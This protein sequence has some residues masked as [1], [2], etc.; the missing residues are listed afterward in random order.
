M[1]PLT[2]PNS[3]FPLRRFP[4]HT[5][6]PRTQPPPSDPLLSSVTRPLPPSPQPGCQRVRR[7]GGRARTCPR[8]P[9]PDNAR[10]N[11]AR[12]RRSHP[13]PANTHP[14]SGSPAEAQAPPGAARGYGGGEATGQ[15]PRSRPATRPQRPR[16]PRKHTAQ[17]SPPDPSRPDVT[18]KGGGDARGSGGGVRKVV[19][20]A[21]AGLR[22]S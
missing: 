16:S 6:S 10:E 11:G 8:R 1:T 15:A 22:L 2:H 18:S 19:G 14:F 9:R 3:G 21:G 17:Q 7:G 4:R 13:A 20:G 5:H 12:A